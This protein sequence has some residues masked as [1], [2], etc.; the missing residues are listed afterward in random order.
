MDDAAFLIFIELNKN[1]Y[2]MSPFYILMF[3]NIVK[4]MHEIFYE[5]NYKNNILNK[6]K[7]NYLIFSSELKNK[8]TKK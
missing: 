6:L 5:I 1:N 3:Y 2:K 4:D 8:V 7:S